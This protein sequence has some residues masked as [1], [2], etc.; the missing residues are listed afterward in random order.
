MNSKF[1]VLSIIFIGAVLF[2]TSCKKESRTT[3]LSAASIDTM[4]IV[5][6][7]IAQ[8]IVHTLS[9]TYGG[10]NVSNG[11]I[12]P[13][14]T[15]RFNSKVSVTG[16][17]NLC[18]F[19]PDTIVNYST[20]VG[21]TIKSQTSGVFKFYFSCD[22]VK[23]PRVRG[24]PVFSVLNGY[25]AYDSLETI[26][27]A[28][29]GAFVHNI[30]SFY[31]AKATDTLNIPLVINGSAN[32]IISING[33]IKSFVDTTATKTTV[34]SSSVHAYYTLADVIVDLTKKGDITKGTATFS[35]LGEVNN[36]KWYYEGSVIFLGNHKVSIVIKTKTY[37]VD[38]LTGKVTA[39]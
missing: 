26:G 19:F 38:L 21:D 29:R 27:L 15:T 11:L 32:N 14:F 24:Y 12:I 35:I 37:T 9:G 2:Y 22:T 31:V 7:Q 3:P 25:A 4:A 23:G 16:L 17:F 20:N 13:G 1:K 30:K 28:P 6:N 5:T 34:T 8:N 39:T 10:V 33:S 36:I 18:T